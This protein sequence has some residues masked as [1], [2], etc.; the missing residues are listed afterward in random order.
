MSSRLLFADPFAASDALTFA[1]RAARLGDGLVRLR[2]D[3]GVIGVTSAP[4]APESLLDETPTI[5]GM[6]FLSVDPELVCDL[7]VEAASLTVDGAS[8]T[9]LVLPDTARS[10]PWAG[11]SPPRGG[12]E[13]ADEITAA[14]LAARAQHGIAEVAESM[15]AEP[16]ADVVRAV[17]ARVWGRSDDDLAGL[18]LGVAFAA[19]SL[20]FIAGEETATIRRSG[21]WT[22]LSLSRGHV[23]TRSTV[24]AGLTAVRAT[25]AAD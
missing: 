16:G 10:A 19:F 4:L 24:R 5:L 23:L 1:Q 11:I 21:P 17:R 15:P 8:T 13:I 20:G 18:P 14:T 2:A 25:G 22:R 7:V 12:W 3:N 6:R 9:S